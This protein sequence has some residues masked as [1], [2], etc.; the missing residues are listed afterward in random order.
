M[1][2][3]GKTNKLKELKITI[4][5]FEDHIVYVLTS[6]YVFEGHFGGSVVD[7]QR[8]LIYCFVF[9]E[10]CLMYAWTVFYFVKIIRVVFPEVMWPLAPDVYIVFV[11]E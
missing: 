5:L 8:S 10:E 4:D 11:R 9:F 6:A 1:W 2:V 3:K 7:A